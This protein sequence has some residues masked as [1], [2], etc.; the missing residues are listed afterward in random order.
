MELEPAEATLL[1]LKS[2]KD[3]PR[4]SL[5]V[6]EYGTH[7][8]FIIE[9]V[10]YLYDLKEGVIRGEHAHRQQS[11]LIICLTGIIEFSTIRHDKKQHFLLTE[12]EK[13][14]YFP[15][16]TW[17]SIQV[18]KAPAIC[19][20]LSSGQYDPDDYIRNYESFESQMNARD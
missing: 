2:F 19:L 16:M 10:F 6:A 18:V 13:G 11:Q 17:V 7:V 4:G 8:P 15:P 1:T 12:P 3:P 14:V 9:R 5:C 20:V